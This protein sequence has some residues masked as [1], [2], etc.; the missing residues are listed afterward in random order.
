[1]TLHTY[2]AELPAYLDDY[3]YDQLSARHEPQG[4]MFSSKTWDLNKTLTYLGTYFPRSYAEAYCIFCDYFSSNISMWGSRETLRILDVGCGCGGELVGLLAAIHEKLPNVTSVVIDAVDANRHAATICENVIDCYAKCNN[5]DELIRVNIV[6]ADFSDLNQTKEMPLQ[7]NGGYDVI[8]T[9]KA[10]NEIITWGSWGCVNPYSEFQ[11]IFSQ[12]LVENGIICIADVDMPVQ[13]MDCPT[14]GIVRAC[15]SGAQRSCFV[16]QMAEFLSAASG[17]NW[18]MAQ[19][20]CPLVNGQPCSCNRGT[21]FGFGR[22]CSLTLSYVFY[23]DL[24]WQAVFNGKFLV[25][26][27]NLDAHGAGKEREKRFYVKHSR[28]SIGDGDS[29]GLFWAI[30]SRKPYLD[31][32]DLPM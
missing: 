7:F 10:L 14:T 15:D 25:L 31:N 26:C 11:D 18:A 22:D 19:G 2:A 16:K 27:H 9:F 28:A 20:N 1:M 4:M 30:S 5:L 21:P 32:G 8:L 24:M 29:E 17:N 3:I 13:L 12:C 23:R 6:R